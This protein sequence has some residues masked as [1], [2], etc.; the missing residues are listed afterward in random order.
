[1]FSS[2]RFI[3]HIIYSVFTRFG[4]FSSTAWGNSAYV[5]MA[6]SKLFS[7]ENAKNKQK[8]EN[9]RST[10]I[11]MGGREH[12]IVSISI[13]ILI[14]YYYDYIMAIICTQIWRWSK[15]ERARWRRW[16]RNYVR[17]GAYAARC[18]WDWM[19]NRMELKGNTLA[20]DLCWKETSL[21]IIND[22]TGGLFIHC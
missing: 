10:T 16:R 14:V 7:N 17:S 22:E 13:M 21:C 11:Y 9:I 3:I 12:W 6:R 8:N 18:H 19:K 20:N 1:M 2:M 5:Y 4:F 15:N